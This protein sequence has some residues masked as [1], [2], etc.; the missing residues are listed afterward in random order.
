MID[1]KNWQMMKKYLEY[2]LQVDQITKGSLKQEQNHMKY[3]LEWGQGQSFRY[4]TGIRPT[5]PEYMLSARLDGK[6]R[7]LSAVHIKKTLATAR[8]FFTWLSDNEAGYKHLK[9]AW[10]KTIK[11]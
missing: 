4:P 1:K 11:A 3:I 7:R 9:Q 8:R 2:R 5:L 6:E 10:I